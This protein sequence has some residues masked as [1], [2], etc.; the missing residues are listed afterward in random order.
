MP[1]YMKSGELGFPNYDNLIYN[2]LKMRPLAFE[3]YPIYSQTGK[4]E[5]TAT[6]VGKNILINCTKVNEAKIYRIQYRHGADSEFENIITLNENQITDFLF[7]FESF[8]DNF[9]YDLTI[10]I[11]MFAINSDGTE[12]DFSNIVHVDFY[13]KPPKIVAAKTISD[14]EVELELS[15][16][17]DPNLKYIVEFYSDNFSGTVKI[18]SGNKFI[19]SNLWGGIKYFFK[20]RVENLDETLFS[21]LSEP[22]EFSTLLVAPD[23]PKVTQI[24]THEA[25]LQW[26]YYDV[27]FEFFGGIFEIELSKDGLNFDKIL[28]LGTNEFSAKI[29]NLAEAT[30]YYFRL[31]AKS[32]DNIY[33]DYSEILKFNTL[34]VGPSKAS[35]KNIKINQML[36]NWKDNSN[37]EKAYQ[38]FQ[39]KGDSFE[40]IA[41]IEANSTEFLVGQLLPNTKYFYKIAAKGKD[42]ISEFTEIISAET[43]TITNNEKEIFS[44]HFRIFPNPIEKQ[45]FVESILPI[46]EKFKIKIVSNDGKTCLEQS[47]EQ[48]I[49]KLN[50]ENLPKGF[51][52]LIIYKK[53]LVFHKKI[54]KN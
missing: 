51:Y 24:A 28:Q 46:F 30:T 23:S 14:S 26:N 44:D 35:I 38:I 29:K 4:P 19:I 40:K 27:F 10:D 13:L 7:R 9:K 33:S 37:G 12:S 18:E 3:N 17:V 6:K 25:I 15:Q 50:L 2:K 32:K 42:A 11:R 41:E 54:L 45:L 49:S 20:I 53:G 8:Y 48:S 21:K 22:F 31:A 36:L 39:K 16:P 5:I 43:L 47:V 1:A 34:P 52:Y